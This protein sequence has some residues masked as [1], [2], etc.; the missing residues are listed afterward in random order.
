MRINSVE[1][2]CNK[3]CTERSPTCHSTCEAY[4]AFVKANEEMKK[5]KQKEYK[6]Q[7]ISRIRRFNK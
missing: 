6:G 5:R 1:I 2:P 3:D 4:I 7:T